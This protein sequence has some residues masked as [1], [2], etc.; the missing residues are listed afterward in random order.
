MGVIT[1]PL[2]PAPAAPTTTVTGTATF[3]NV[4]SDLG[5]GLGNL[6]SGSN[7]A[8]DYSDDVS[9]SNGIS[10]DTKLSGLL[11]SI[12]PPDDATNRNDGG[13]CTFTSYF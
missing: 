2:Q 12:I 6:N 13:Q 9:E 8:L 5:L 10:G 11:E 7:I 4:R 1:E 3:Y